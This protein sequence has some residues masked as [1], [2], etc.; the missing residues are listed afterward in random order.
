MSGTEND[1]VDDDGEDAG[2][3]DTGEPIDLAA[4]FRNIVQVLQV[5]PRDYRKFGV[6]WWPVKALLRRAGYDRHQLYMLGTYQDPETAAMVPKAGLQ[7]TMRSALAEYVFNST[8]PHSD[9]RVEN[10]AG[11][12][13]AI[14]DQ[15]AEL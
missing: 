12:L 15:D 6:W 13:V 14:Q 7:A 10:A 2:D 8:Y 1:G 4:A 3:D 9:G 11:E 5:N